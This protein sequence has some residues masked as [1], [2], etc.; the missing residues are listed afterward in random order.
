MTSK[1]GRRPSATFNKP[2]KHEETIPPF[3]GSVRRVVVPEISLAY[4]QILTAPGRRAARALT[5]EV[6][7]DIYAYT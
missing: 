3:L 2:M 4:A 6:N 5:S 7:Y 1:P